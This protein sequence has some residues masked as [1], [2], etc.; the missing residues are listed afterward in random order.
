MGAS[1]RHPVPQPSAEKKDEEVVH[2]SLPL[3]SPY[4]ASTPLHGKPRKRLQLIGER[5]GDS[6]A[7]GRVGRNSEASLGAQ[8]RS[9]QKARGFPLCCKAWFIH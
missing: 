9:V 4:I 1:A 2:P 3:L 7:E 8:T 6:E 5:F